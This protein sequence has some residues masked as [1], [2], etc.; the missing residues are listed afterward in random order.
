MKSIY[1]IVWIIYVIS[2]CSV[3]TES[4]LKD[5]HVNTKF[6]SKSRKNI[7]SKCQQNYD[8]LILSIEKL[9][10]ASNTFSEISKSKNNLEKANRLRENCGLLVGSKAIKLRSY[11]LDQRN[12]AEEALKVFPTDKD[13]EQRLAL[14]TELVS[15][16]PN[17]P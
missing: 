1:L 15:L 3:I 17:V 11:F 14:Y 8:S 2:G 10:I 12:G 4:D 7:D 9:V 5:N 13:L 6:E 16:I